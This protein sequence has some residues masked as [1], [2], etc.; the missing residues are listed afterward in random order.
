MHPGDIAQLES[1]GT[2]PLLRPS[3]RRWAVFVL[4]LV[5]IFNFAD[6]AILAVLAQPIKEDLHLTDTDLGVLQGIAFAILYSVL[7]IPLGMLAERASRTRLLAACVAVWSCMTV[8][9]GFAGSFASLMLGR[10]G[11]GIGEAGAQPITNSLIS[12]FFKRDSRGSALAITLLGAPLG[13]LLGQSVGG[14]VA[15]EWGWRAAFYVLGIPGVLVA[16]LIVLTLREPPRGLSDGGAAVRTGP[17]PSLREIIACLWSKRTFRH[18]LFAYVVASFTLNAIATFVLPFYLR[19]FGVPL[20]T[21]AILFGIVSFFSNGLGML[22]GGFGIDRL[23]R[24]DPRWALWGPAIALVLCVPVYFGAFA[25]S[26]LYTS[27]AFVFLGNFALASTMAPT[28]ATMQN[29]VGPRMRATTSAINLFVIGIFGAGLGPTT[30]GVLSDLFA[31]R[32]FAGA[33]FIASCPGGRGIGGPG[34]PLDAACLAASTDGLRYALLSMLAV[35]LWAGLH[36]FIAARYLRTDLYDP[37]K[38]VSAG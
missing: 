27:L 21:I 18:L 32:A 20:A 9:C 31:K 19:G 6:R 28:M 8:A 33:D 2:H 14:L 22:V 10:V 30:T 38:D 5:A 3:Y 12:D 24:R 13:F 1:A 34:S 35:F 29:L 37:A 17:A 11:V 7:G 16:L 4:L 26:A 15:S 25:G 36:Y 23:S